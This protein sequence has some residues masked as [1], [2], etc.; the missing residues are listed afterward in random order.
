M[1]DVQAKSDVRAIF[2]G[3]C[4]DVVSMQ[5]SDRALEVTI[6]MHDWG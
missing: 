3:A 2:D 4:R 6:A 1:R 5:L